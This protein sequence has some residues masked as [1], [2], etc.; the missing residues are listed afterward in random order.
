MGRLLADGPVHSA[1]LPLLQH[2]VGQNPFDIVAYNKLGVTLIGLNRL[3]EA[4]NAFEQ[5]LRVDSHNLRGMNNLAAVK[6]R[7]GDY[8]HARPLLEEI[9]KVEPTATSYTNLAI[10]HIGEGRL[11][12][13]LPFVERARKMEPDS[14]VIAGQLANLYR[15][16]GAEREAR[17]EY[18]E[19]VRLCQKE[20]RVAL[21]A[22]K[23]A[24]LAF[25]YASL[26]D[27]LSCARE[28][29]R[30]LKSDSSDLDVLHKQAD[31]Q[32]LTGDKQACLETV[33]FLIQK[34]YPLALLRADRDLAEALQ[35]IDTSALPGV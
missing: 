9:L 7:L 17:A 2:A 28:F 29:S 18:Q 25:Y 3:A 4:A 24:D 33:R 30:A 21:S 27:R 1:G 12:E 11:H 31:A 16:L 20:L 22:P 26:N 19:A 23:L 8:Q 5:I 6:L 32:A 34:H 35:S 13:A 15:W 10:V 14:E